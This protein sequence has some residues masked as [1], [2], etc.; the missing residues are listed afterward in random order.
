MISFIKQNKLFSEGRSHT[1]GQKKS[2]EGNIKSISSCICKIQWNDVEC[3][4]TTYLRCTTKDKRAQA[5]KAAESKDRHFS[6][7]TES[8]S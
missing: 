8:D 7:R 4:T 2:K 6:V 5:C 3:S 1:R